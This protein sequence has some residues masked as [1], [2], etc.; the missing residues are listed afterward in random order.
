MALSVYKVMIL[1]NFFFNQSYYYKPEILCPVPTY[2]V[3]HGT[4]LTM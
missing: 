3:V 2:L 1:Q 4:S